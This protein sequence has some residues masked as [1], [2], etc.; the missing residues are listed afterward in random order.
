MT[1]LDAKIKEL[2]ERLKLL[3]PAKRCAFSAACSERFIGL[4]G[5]FS[6]KDGWGNPDTL[7]EIL[8]LVWLSTTQ[9]QESPS[10][11][12]LKA[13]LDLVIN[14]LTPHTDLFSSMECV[15]AQAVCSSLE[16]AIKSRLNT[17]DANIDEGNP[18][19]SPFEAIRAAVCLSETG[20]VDLGDL[21]EAAEFEAHLLE[22]LRVRKELD[23]QQQDLELLS[24]SPVDPDITLYL[25]ERAAENR[26]TVRQLLPIQ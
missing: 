3:P 15:L 26:W 5:E 25:K 13:A 12:G 11:E 24:R 17:L 21:P 23:W 6:K 7:R 19:G 22:D 18:V 14:S 4:Y 8:E 20:Y 16:A 2:R 9:E 1:P 10:R